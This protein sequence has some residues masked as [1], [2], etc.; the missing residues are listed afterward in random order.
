MPETELTR[1]WGWYCD[2]IRHPALQL[3]LF[4]S[5]YPDESDLGPGDEQPIQVA[6]AALP[7]ARLRRGAL[8]AAAHLVYDQ[9]LFDLTQAMLGPKAANLDEERFV[10]DH[11]PQRYAH[12]YDAEFHRK[13]LVTVG[14]V[15]QD[16][17]DPH[18]GYPACTAEEMVLAAI[19]EQWQV[20]LDLAEIDHA[21]AD[22]PSYLLQDLDFENL[23][24]PEFDGIE[25]DPLAHKTTG[26][27]VRPFSQWFAPFNAGDRV[28]P[29]AAVQPTPAGSTYD[30]THT[31]RE[32]HADPHAPTDQNSILRGLEPISSFVEAARNAADRTDLPRLVIPDPHDP[33]GSFAALTAASGRS[34]RLSFQ[35]A[36]DGDIRTE[37]VLSFT[38]NRAHPA[39]G[40]CWS[41][42]L[43]FSG[44][45]ELPLSALVS[46]E[47]DPGVRAEW[48][49]VFRLFDR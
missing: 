47:P 19:I 3:E 18:A 22:L 33:A 13:L 5:D 14:K 36:D 11:F 8:L 15:A 40:Q 31:S 4:T 1:E 25:D 20:L 35:L 43:F 37:P 17:T 44:R 7:R 26:I 10:D 48:E 24:A 49:N 2:Q 29:F 28:H 27:D 32:E 39:T 9:V 12:A 6:A 16:L 38:P 42:I 41:E 46:F 45:I 23:F 30:L 34:G 21:W